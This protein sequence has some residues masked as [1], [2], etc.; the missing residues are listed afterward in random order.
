MAVRSPSGDTIAGNLTVIPSSQK[1]VFHTMY[2]FA[3]PHL[4]SEEVCSR[5]RLVLTDE[6]PSEYTP[7]ENLISTTNHFKNSNVMLC[8][9]HAIW[10]AFRQKIL[11][12]YGNYKH[13]QEYGDWV[14]RLF[15]HQNVKRYLIKL[16]CYI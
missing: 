6:D 15:M 1:W 4:Y 14:Y 5:N 9:F 16:P 3:F 13:A 8:T 2:K 7:M 12:L 11:P 10:M